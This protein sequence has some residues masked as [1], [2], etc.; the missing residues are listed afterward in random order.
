MVLYSCSQSR[1]IHYYRRCNIN[2]SSNEQEQEYEHEHE[3]EHEKVEVR[4]QDQE[5]DQEQQKYQEQQ[6]LQEQEDR[7]NRIDGN[8]RRNMYRNTNINHINIMLERF[9]MIAP[10]CSQI[11]ATKQRFMFTYGWYILISFPHCSSLF[12]GES[13]TN[14]GMI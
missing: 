5:Q 10:N 6:K 8:N 4:E 2:N 9:E 11:W 3:H 1:T 12:L 7:I 13:D 14:G